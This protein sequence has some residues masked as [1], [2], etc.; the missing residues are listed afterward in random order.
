MA[1]E[2]ADA[3]LPVADDTRAML[4]REWQ[5]LAGPGSWCSGA[6]RVAIAAEARAARGGLS[7]ESDLAAPLSEAAGVVETAAATITP[8]WVAE[9]VEPAAAVEVY[10][11]TV[12]V[13]GRLA[14]VDAY[15]CGVGAEPEPLPTPQPG[16][17]SRQRNPAAQ[18]RA[19]F[20]PT[21]PEDRPPAVLSAVPAERDAQMD[22]LGVFYLSPEQMG[23]LAYQGHLSRPQ[24]ELLAARTS[25][26]ND[27]GY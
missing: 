1:F 14:A 10:V 22:L 5:R 12:G 20:V 17:P 4:R 24:I 27:C 21:D 3:V 13:V 23:D 18:R 9:L 16:E 7:G 8:A 25:Y 15:V 26:L 11:E 6:E 2:L 19:A